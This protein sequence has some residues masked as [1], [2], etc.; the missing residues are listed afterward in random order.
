[1]TADQAQCHR[2]SSALEAGTVRYTWHSTTM[3]LT[4]SL[5]SGSTNTMFFITMCHSVVRSRAV[6]VREI[7]IS[8]KV[9]RVLMVLSSIRS[10]IG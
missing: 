3:K 1:M 7:S 8:K 2:V 6:L 5:R 10:G 9:P 4:R